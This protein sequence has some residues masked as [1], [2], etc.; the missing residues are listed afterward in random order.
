MGGGKNRGTPL[1]YF[2]DKVHY[3]EKVNLKLKSKSVSTLDMELG[4]LRPREKYQS[5]KIEK[6]N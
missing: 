1:N 6:Q 5:K 3:N 4:C 2:C